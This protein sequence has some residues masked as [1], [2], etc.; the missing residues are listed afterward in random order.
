MRKLLYLLYEPYKWLILV[1]VFAAS[2]VAFAALAIVLAMVVSPRA[3]SVI[4]GT[5]W[6]RLNAWL[7]PMLVTVIGRERVD[8]EQSY[9]IAANHQSGYDVF[10]LYGWLGLDFKWVMKHELRKVPAL[11]IG[12][13]KLEHVF[14]DRSNTEAAIHT[15]ETAKER[16][17]DGTSV[18][19]FPEG[20]R[21]PDGKL[22][23]FKKGAFRMAMDL[24]LPIL[25]VTIDGTRDVMP[26]KTL[27]VF[28]GRA[29]LIFHPPV[30]VTGLDTGDLKPLMRQVK[31][32]IE[33]GLS[34]ARA[35]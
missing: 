11:G 8:R 28:P 2:T 19:F 32:T 22:L 31:A 18:V 4:C 17:R 34:S 13:E 24:G 35:G 14:I 12:C 23:P 15:L 10:L 30:D 9:V 27:R 25:P 33:S 16:I 3:G 26:P 6:A 21:S 5:A 7:T 1:P 29:R 20:T